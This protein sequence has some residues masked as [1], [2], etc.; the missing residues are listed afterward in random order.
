MGILMSLR[1]QSAK[2]Q[3]S[4][5]CLL[6]GSLQLRSTSLQDI[7]PCKR[8]KTTPITLPGAARGVPIRVLRVMLCENFWLVCACTCE[9]AICLWQ[10]VPC[11]A[12][13]R[14]ILLSVSS[15]HHFMSSLSRSYDFCAY[16]RLCAG[17]SILLLLCIALYSGRIYIQNM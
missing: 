12:F 1:I 11:V 14:V 10:R 5:C 13:G 9:H 15:R 16:L 7:G 17:H 6:A 4:V 3:V 2:I 8:R